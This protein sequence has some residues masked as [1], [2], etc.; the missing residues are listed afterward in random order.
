MFDYTTEIS[1]LVFLTPR[2]I[3]EKCLI[4]HTD[5]NGN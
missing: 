2:Y 5:I 1:F 3:P 4:L